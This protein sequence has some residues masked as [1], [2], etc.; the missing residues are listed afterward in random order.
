MN[1]LKKR[2]FK[3]AP[4]LQTALKNESFFKKE[5]RERQRKW[6]ANN[7]KLLSIENKL[8]VTRGVSGQGMG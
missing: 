3:D 1:V 2:I 7:K 4:G 8:R 6:E 5:K